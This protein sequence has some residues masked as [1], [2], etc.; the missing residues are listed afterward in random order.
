MWERG[1]G[2]CPYTILSVILFKNELFTPRDVAERRGHDLIVEYLTQRHSALKHVDIP[3]DQRRMSKTNIE[4][5][6]RIARLQQAVASV[7]SEDFLDSKWHPEKPFRRGKSM[8]NATYM[9]NT[10]VNTSVRFKSFFKLDNN[11][12]T[13]RLP[14]TM[15]SVARCFFYKD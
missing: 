6:L 4:E 14:S 5:Q 11:P 15:L 7:E 1:G 13:I 8:G 9:V 2:Y 3:E 10:G 12:E